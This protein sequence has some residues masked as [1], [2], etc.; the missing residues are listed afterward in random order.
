MIKIGIV[1]KVLETYKN[2]FELSVEKNLL[3]LLKKKLKFKNVDILTHNSNL[4]KY[5]II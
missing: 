3:I 5:N 4:N 2:Q 1:P